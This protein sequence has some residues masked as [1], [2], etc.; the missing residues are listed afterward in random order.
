MNNKAILWM[1]FT[2]AFLILIT[3]LSSY[4]VTFKWIF[5]LVILGQAF[6]II[7]VYK[8]LKDDYK[9]ELTFK[10]GYQDHPIEK[11]IE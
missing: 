7:T 6:L 1:I 2:T 10:D 5:S 11:E 8:V 3:I 4:N 9:T